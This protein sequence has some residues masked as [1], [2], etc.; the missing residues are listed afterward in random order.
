MFCNRGAYSVDKYYRLERGWSWF[1]DE[2][3]NEVTKQAT[4]TRLEH[5]QDLS[6]SVLPIF[7]HSRKGNN[8]VAT[9]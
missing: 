3:P 7:H 1:A 5:N 4:E 8:I 9:L 6:C 2:Q